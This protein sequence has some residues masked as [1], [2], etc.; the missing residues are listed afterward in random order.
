MPENRRRLPLEEQL[1]YVQARLEEASSGKHSIGQ[2]RRAKA[3]RKELSIIKRKLAHQREGALGGA[4]DPLGGGGGP[5]AD[6]GS[7]P[8]RPSAAAA[9]A[10]A[11]HHDEGE[12]S[13]SQ[14]LGGKGRYRHP[15]RSRRFAE[16]RLF[17]KGPGE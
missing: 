8:H 11:G 4:R 9:A 16:K 17:G 15:S 3:L 13:S 1:H 2:S 5:G 6:R 7:L 14:E 10:A 12:E